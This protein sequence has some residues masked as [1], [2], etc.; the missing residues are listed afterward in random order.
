MTGKVQMCRHLR[1]RQLKL[2]EMHPT[3]A[4]HTLLIAVTEDLADIHIFRIASSGT[5][6]WAM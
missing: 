5:A 4:A 6:G 1:V 2:D 3:Q